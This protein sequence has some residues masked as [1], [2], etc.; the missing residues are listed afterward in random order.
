MTYG[1]EVLNA[2][3]RTVFN[4]DQNYPNYYSSAGPVT[5]NGYEP[6]PSYTAGSSTILLG[7]PH[8]NAS[9]AIFYD[10]LAGRF[11]A[12]GGGVV[13][14]MRATFGIANGVRYAKFDSQAAITPATSG[15]G[16]EVFNS[17]GSILYSSNTTYGFNILAT[18]TLQ[19]VMDVTYTPPSGVAFNTVFVTAMSFT[20]AFLY[21]AAVF[22][23]PDFYTFFGSLAHF[24]NST[25]TIT[26]RQVN[27]VQ[28]VTCPTWQTASN[29]YAGTNARR[30][31][32]IV[33]VVS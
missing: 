16:A 30:D 7:R 10:P 33:E 13:D 26:L 27:I 15:Y 21:S 1:I 24:N 22:P 18:G 19:G 32:M 29:Y 17:S 6:N 23:A 8:S 3:G 25:S 20:G 2:S 5:A 31:Y 14:S 9:G 12:C 4:T 11:G 28:G